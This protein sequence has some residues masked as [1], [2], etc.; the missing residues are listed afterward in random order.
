MVGPFGGLLVHG[1]PTRRCKAAAD[2]AGAVVWRRGLVI[3]NHA[4]A[5]P[6]AVVG[7]LRQLEKSPSGALGMLRRR[8]SELLCG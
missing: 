6:I 2:F 8:H 1:D 4:K 7:V 3:N 5:P